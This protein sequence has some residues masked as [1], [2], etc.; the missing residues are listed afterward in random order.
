M[1]SSNL[2]KS[3]KPSVTLSFTLFLV[4]LLL[5]VCKHCVADGGGLTR[6]VD[7]EVIFSLLIRLV[8][9]MEERLKARS[10]LLLDLFPIGDVQ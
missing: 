7:D 9:F 3:A 2:L 8:F 6:R 1:V 10:V 5:G 4:L